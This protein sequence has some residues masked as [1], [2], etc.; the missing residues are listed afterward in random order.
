[1]LIQRPRNLIVGLGFQYSGPL[2]FQ[3]WF[4]DTVAQWEAAHG[5]PVRVMVQAGGSID[6]A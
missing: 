5:T 4:M 2:A 3:R 1:M 6:A